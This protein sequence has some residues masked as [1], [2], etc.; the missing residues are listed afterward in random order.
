MHLKISELCTLL[1]AFCSFHFILVSDPFILAYAIGIL[2]LCTCSLTKVSL[3]VI[4]WETVSMFMY[5]SCSHIYIQYWMWKGYK[6][7]VCIHMLLLLL[8]WQRNLVK[9]SVC[10]LVFFR[11][12]WYA[13]PWN[14]I[15]TVH[16]QSKRI[17][18]HIKQIEWCI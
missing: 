6:E 4:K 2:Q 12:C 14:G 10:S 9:R 15:H 13:N 5:H 7:N 1:K 8:W 18:L 11:V 17:W 16:G 3:I